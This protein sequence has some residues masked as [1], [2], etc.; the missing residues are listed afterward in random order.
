MPVSR[1]L[2]LITLFPLTGIGEIGLDRQIMLQTRRCLVI[3]LL[4][5]G[6]RGPSWTQS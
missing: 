5:C 4:E 6:L 3:A 1:S 2:I